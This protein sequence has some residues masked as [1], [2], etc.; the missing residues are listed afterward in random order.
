[1]RVL[2]LDCLRPIRRRIVW[3]EGA[4][5]RCVQSDGVEV[6]ACLVWCGPKSM[7]EWIREGEAE[8]RARTSGRRGR[9]CILLGNKCGNRGSTSVKGIYTFFHTIPLWDKN[10]VLQPPPHRSSQ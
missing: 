6:Q 3:V 10:A 2:I 9:R 8:T 4:G 7:C 5:P 1:M